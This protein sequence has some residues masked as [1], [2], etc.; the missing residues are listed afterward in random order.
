MAFPPPSL[1]FSEGCGLPRHPAKGRDGEGA[2]R[3]A[4]AKRGDGRSRPPVEA[5]AGGVIEPL[6]GRSQVAARESVGKA[7]AMPGPAPMESQK[8]LGVGQKRAG[9]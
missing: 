4:W 9:D 7:A 1:R 5:A 2:V 6:A 3:P 8:S